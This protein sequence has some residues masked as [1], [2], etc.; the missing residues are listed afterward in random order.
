MLILV[1]LLAVVVMAEHHLTGITIPES[2]LVAV[3]A[4]LEIKGL[5]V[6]DGVEP[7][8]LKPTSPVNLP[9]GAAFR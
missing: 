3:E 2:F 7:A 9:R 5:G 4:A 1:N 6:A 8:W